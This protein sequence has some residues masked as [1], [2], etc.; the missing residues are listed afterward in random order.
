MVQGKAKYL[1]INSA[2]WVWNIEPWRKLFDTDEKMVACK[3]LSK[4]EVPNMASTLGGGYNISLFNV[5]GN[6]RT[7]LITHKD[8]VND[9]IRERPELSKVK[10]A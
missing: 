4:S 6:G 3:I 5:I 8:I 1:K 10:I 2:I 7:V 9:K